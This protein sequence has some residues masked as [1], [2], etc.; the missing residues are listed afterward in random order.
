MQTLK[1]GSKGHESLTWALEKKSQ[2][3]SRKGRIHAEE[4]V[5]R[6][7]SDCRRGDG[8]DIVQDFS[9]FHPFFT[10]VKVPFWYGNSQQDGKDRIVSPIDIFF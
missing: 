4:K 5:V 10:V 7:A 9:E 8:V 3:K 1:F 6:G 2:G